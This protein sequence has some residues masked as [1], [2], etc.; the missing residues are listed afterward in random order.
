MVFI[1]VN[2]DTMKVVVGLP[3]WTHKEQGPY[4]PF[5]VCGIDEK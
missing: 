1:I 4:C 3:G 2:L 5:F